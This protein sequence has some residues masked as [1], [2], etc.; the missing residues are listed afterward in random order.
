MES[1]NSIFMQFVETEQ[2]EDFWI[3]KDD[4][5]K[6]YLPMTA[7]YFVSD[8]FRNTIKRFFREDEEKLE[9][10]EYIADIINATIID[11]MEL[12]DTYNT[13]NLDTTNTGRYICIRNKELDKVASAVGDLTL[14]YVIDLGKVKTFNY[15]E[16][17]C[18][19]ID[20]IT[21]DCNLFLEISKN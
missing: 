15:E 9:G 7:Q 18:F 3:W 20:I 2:I 14:G 4:T 10:Y 13:I 19:G 17:G 5:G 16:R 8:N 21:G 6:W 1:K 12:R 11:L